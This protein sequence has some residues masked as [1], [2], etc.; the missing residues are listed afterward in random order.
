MMKK[1]VYTFLFLTSLI[2]SYGQT[3]VDDLTMKSGEVCIA[4][5]IAEEKWD[6]Y[7]EATQLIGNQNIGTFT[8]QTISPMIGIGITNKIN[9]FA[10]L[11]NISTFAS[12]GQ[13]RGDNGF[14][15]IN[16]GLKYKVFSLNKR[17][18]NFN[19]F[20]SSNYTLPVTNYAADYLPF[21]IGLGAQTL[22][23]RAILMAGAFNEKIFLRGSVGYTHVGT[24]EI[25]RSYYYAD[26]SYYS[27]IMDVPSRYVYDVNI[28]S[29]L[30][31]KSIHLEAGLNN[32]TS[33]GG[34][35]I[36]RHL[37]GQPTNKMDMTNLTGRVRIFPLPS[38]SII[39]GYT[40]TFNGR[41]V[42]KAVGY[43]L[44]FTHQFSTKK[45]KS[46]I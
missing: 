4:L 8:K 16:V 6:E 36:R 9:F 46:I 42:G 17:Q 23:M 10:E 21:S 41:N 3:L 44:T 39:L 19:L 1:L 13:I 28:G 32:Q 14:Q 5:N 40:Y 12:A 2:N 25:E 37:A 22:T 34:D 35:D 29:R 27:T 18:E 7:W 24:T 45:S 38:S 26:G 33:I 15:D 43:N 30:F 11:P 20:V 31:N